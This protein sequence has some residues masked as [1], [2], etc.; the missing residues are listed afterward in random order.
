MSIN[1]VRIVIKQV[2][3]RFGCRAVAFDYAGLA[4][5]ESRVKPFGFTG[6]AYDECAA[7]A[8]ELGYLPLE[9]QPRGTH[10]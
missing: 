5:C 3:Q 1:S 4:V 10:A 7:R 2:G 9:D 8:K 6:A